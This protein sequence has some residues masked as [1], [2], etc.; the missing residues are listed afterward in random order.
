[1]NDYN[2]PDSQSPLDDSLPEESSNKA[3]AGPDPAAIPGES[4]VPT[5][6]N[7]IEDLSEHRQTVISEGKAAQ[8][9]PKKQTSADVGRTLQGAQLEHFHLE[10]FVG[11]GGMGAVFRATDEKLGR[12]VAVKVLSRNR[13]DVDSLR[14]FKNE[15]QSAAR[16]DHPNIARVFYVGEDAGWNFI[17][18]EYISG[19]NIRDLVS[20]RGPLSLQ[21]CWSYVLQ[22]ADALTHASERDIVHRDIKPSNILVTSDG[23]AKLV[24]MGLARFHQLESDNSDVTASGVTLGTFDYISPEQARDPRNTDVRGDIYSLGCTLYYMLTGRAPY[25]AGTVLQKLLSHSGDP[26]PDPRAYREEL[27]D[28]TVQILHKMLAK[29]PSTRYQ[30]P[31]ELIEDVTSVGEHLGLTLSHAGRVWVSRISRPQF[32]FIKHVPWIAPLLVLL[33]SRT[34][35]NSDHPK[36]CSSYRRRTYFQ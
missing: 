1:M 11:G 28:G 10:E 22:V 4:S 29:Q 21:D 34:S 30:T 15:A 18:F 16:L 13:K 35:V 12:T 25:P 19:I 27:D 36:Q 6:T 8:S 7:Q 24:D 5:Q 31:N 33:I 14:R 32:S 9:H 23:T 3:T 26:V 20:Q 17:V 2:N